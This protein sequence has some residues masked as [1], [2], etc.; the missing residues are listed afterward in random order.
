MV[1]QITLLIKKPGSD[2]SEL[3]NYQPIT[4]LNTFGKILERLEQNKLCQHL[5]TSPNYYTS[6]SAYQALHSRETA[7]TKVANDLL[8]AVDNGKPT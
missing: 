5:S 7:M 8:T 1:D 6:Q 3:S 4:N 2:V